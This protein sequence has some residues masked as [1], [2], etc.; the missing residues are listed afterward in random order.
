MSEIP[1][2]LVVDDEDRNLRLIDAM[3]KTLDYK[4]TLARNGKEAFEKI[5]SIH[6][7][8]ILLDV[9]MPVIDGYEVLRRLK[10]DNETRIIPVVMI[11]ALNEVEDRVKAIEAGAD[12]FL[13][14]PINR[15]ELQARVKSLLK[16]KYYNDHM[17]NYQKKLEMEVERRT[18]QMQ[19]A[20]KETKEATLDTIQRL[21]KA[22]EYRDEDTGAH[23]LRMSNYSATIASKMGLDKEDVEAILYASPMHDIGKIGIPDRILLKPGKLDLHEWEIMKEHTLIGGGILEGA[24]SDFL[25]LARVIALNHHE[26]WSGEGYPK[27]LKGERIPLPGR[28]TA[29]ADVFDALTSKR[30]YKEAFSVEKSFKIILE[31]R[32]R[33]FDPHVTDA[34]FASKD[35]I[36]FIK[37]KYKDK[38]ESLFIQL[39][40]K[41]SSDNTLT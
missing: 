15:I 19:E 34:F 10:G 13:S 23:I 20:F 40:N 32:G 16:V 27:G 33:R 28:I 37:E 11:T 35:E 17:L 8:L 26:E 30:P 14:K 1:K 18:K 38:Q 22:A 6:P 31:G 3:L 25:K 12:D 4:V 7:D 5:E 21:S 29:I 39:S 9:M 36:L 24:N 2:I 41:I